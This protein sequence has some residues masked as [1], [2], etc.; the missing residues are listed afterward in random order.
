MSVSDFFSQFCSALRIGPS[1]RGNIAARTQAITRRCNL[2]F[3]GLESNTA[4][5]FY[6]G[7]YGRSTAIP[8]VSDIDLIC[9]LPFGVYKQYDAYLG[10]RQSALLQ[11]VKQSIGRT[12]SS[13]DLGGDGQVV[14]VRFSDGIKYD[15]LPAFANT[16]GSYTFADSNGGGKW[17][18]CKPKEEIAEFSKRNAACNGNLVELARMARAWRD[19]NNV[20]MSG[21]LIDTLAYQFIGSWEWREKSY[22]YYDWMTR[23]FFSFLAALPES[24]NYW[25]APGSGSYVYKGGSFTYKARQAELRAKEAINFMQDEH[26]WSAKQKFREIYGTAFPY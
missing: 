21:M 12:Y 11:A 16:D 24:K 1:L 15:V 14:V 10:N 5:S 4:N 25:L 26:F 22:V 18:S 19:T 13:T 2:D 3:R 7:S 8:S 23:D 17:R 20:P 9:V 6:G